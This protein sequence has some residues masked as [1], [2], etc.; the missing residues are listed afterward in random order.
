MR[1][2]LRIEIIKSGQTQRHIATLAGMH[3]N[4]LSDVVRGYVDPRP[5]ER[6]RLMTVLG[7]GPRAFRK[8]AGTTTSTAA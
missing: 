1:T 3:E 7:C 5:D 6:E 8:S 2:K 4:R